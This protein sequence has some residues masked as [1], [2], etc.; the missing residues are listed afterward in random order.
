MLLSAAEALERLKAGNERYLT[1]Q[2]C[3]GDISP[4]LRLH[5]SVHGHQNLKIPFSSPDALLPEKHAA[6]CIEPDPKHQGKKQG[7]KQ[8]Q[9]GR[10]E[11]DIQHPFDPVPIQTSF[12]AVPTAGCALQRHFR[13]L[14]IAL[15]NSVG[16]QETY[17]SFSALNFY[18][19]PFSALTSIRHL[20]GALRCQT[21][22]SKKYR[23]TQTRF[24]RT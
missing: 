16:L 1:A 7:R 9:H 23:V 2:S 3:P 8:E 20:I 4:R 15:C 5:T 10:C 12:M 21:A 22:I 19:T 11:Q 6:L 24:R 14:S 13:F 17:R 18:Y